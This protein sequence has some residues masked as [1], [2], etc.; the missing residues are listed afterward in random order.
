[1]I[2]RRSLTLLVLALALLAPATAHA[3]K[4]K[5]KSSTPKMFITL[6][7]G[8]MNKTIKPTIKLTFDP[9]KGTTAATACKGKI[10]IS[11]PIG[12]KIVKKKPKTLFAHNVA[13]IT[14]ADGV[15]TATSTLRIPAAFLGTKLKFTA[16]FKGN[17]AVKKFSKS[18]KFLLVVA[19]PVT[20]PVVPPPAAGFV[21]TLG[22]WKI[23][24]TPLGS[25]LS[26]SMIVGGDRSVPA[27]QRFGTVTMTCEG[28]V[29]TIGVDQTKAPF[30]TPFAITT[31]DV[32]VTDEWAGPGSTPE[33][34]RT[35]FKFQFDSAGHAT[36]SFRMVGA[37][38]GL[39]SAGN[40]Q[41]LYPNC[42]SGTLPIDLVPGEFS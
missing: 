17:D 26:W 6:T 23:R 2:T 7:D 22:P 39:N 41:I 20:P 4:A 16:V 12:K 24:Q 14:K 3:D 35:T 5:P 19:Q 9:P 42:D 10:K 11:A 1:M 29:A 28:S 36:G 37:L 32:T 40:A 21:P 31:T 30:D 18:S 13:Q 25:G 27:I 15:C 34:I 38:Y 8:A 33:H